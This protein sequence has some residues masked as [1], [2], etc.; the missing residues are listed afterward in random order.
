MFGNIILWRYIVFVCVWN[1]FILF[2][3]H[4]RA[5]RTNH[6]FAVSYSKFGLIKRHCQVLGFLTFICVGL[7]ILLYWPVF[8]FTCVGLLVFL[9]WPVFTFACVG[10]LVLLYWP[11]FTFTCVGLLVLL[12]WPV[13]TYW[14]SG[15]SSSMKC[16]FMWKCVFSFKIKE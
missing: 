9:Y 6:N 14:N 1:V 13:F 7:L 5:V 12:Y 2:R 4:N 15:V 3:H 8:T 11:V 10:L 16:R